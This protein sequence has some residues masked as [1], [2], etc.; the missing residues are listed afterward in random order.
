MAEQLNLL[1][2]QHWARFSTQNYFDPQG[3]FMSTLVSA[4]LL[5]IMF[6]VLVRA[7]SR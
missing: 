6:T 2:R 3:V 7:I 1:G 4:P 5:L